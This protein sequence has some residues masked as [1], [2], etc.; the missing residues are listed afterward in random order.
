MS[1]V[2]FS[3]LAAWSSSS[4]YTGGWALQRGREIQKQQCRHNV[5]AGKSMGRGATHSQWWPW[6]ESLTA[7]SAMSCPK[8]SST[9]RAYKVW[10]Q[11]FPPGIPTTWCTN[12]ASLPPLKNQHEDNTQE[13]LRKNTPGSN[14]T[15]TPWEQQNTQGPASRAKPMCRLRAHSP[16]AAHPLLLSRGAEA[17]THPRAQTHPCAQTHTDPLLFI[18]RGLKL[19]SLGL[20]ISGKTEPLHSFLLLTNPRRTHPTAPCTQLLKTSKFIKRVPAFIIFLSAFWLTASV[21][22]GFK[23]GKHG[24]KELLQKGPSLSAT[25]LDDIEGEEAAPQKS[26]IGLCFLTVVFRCEHM[27]K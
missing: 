9:T 25:W 18:S 23:W 24:R 1:T 19:Q 7:R 27:A 20:F 6:G 5:C 17:H 15:L 22:W 14:R 2:H 13:D 10:E 12:P 11:A 21:S 16:A 8:S 3:L 4:T 26:K